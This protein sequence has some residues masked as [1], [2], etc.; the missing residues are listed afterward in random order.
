MEREEC[1]D[2]QMLCNAFLHEVVTQIRDI[3]ERCV[4]M[5]RTPYEKELVDTVFKAAETMKETGDS[6]SSDEICHC[7]HAAETLLDLMLRERLTLHKP[8]ITLL[9]DA[10]ALIKKTMDHLPSA[11]AP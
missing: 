2:V 5:E 1:L 6:F 4:L 7:I 10:A 3:E 11:T 8:T 9:L